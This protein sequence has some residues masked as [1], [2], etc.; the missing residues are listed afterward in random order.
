[1]QILSHASFVTDASVWMSNTIPGICRHRISHEF[2]FMFSFRALQI[3]CQNAESSW[4]IWGV[5]GD[6]SVCAWA[7]VLSL[8]EIRDVNAWIKNEHLPK[9]WFVC[10]LRLFSWAQMR[11]FSKC[12]RNILSATKTNPRNG[13]KLYRAATVAVAKPTRPS[14]MQT[15]RP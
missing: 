6:V 3:R 15:P 10:S 9:Y 7:C 13:I 8:G 1:M 4:V 12:L 5:E 11:V 2:G 14:K